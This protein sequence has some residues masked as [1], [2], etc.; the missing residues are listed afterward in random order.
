V[1][2]VSG[3][4]FD[5]VTGDAS[6]DAGSSRAADPGDASADAERNEAGDA[7]AE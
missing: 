4:C 7:R 5:V 6:T 2:T 1:C 3:Q